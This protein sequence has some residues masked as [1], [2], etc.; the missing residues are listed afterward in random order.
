[1]MKAPSLLLLLFFCWPRIASPQCI[2]APA[3]PACTGTEP[4]LT[5]DETL[6]D[7]TTKWYYGPAVTMNSLTLNGGTL[8][9]CGDLTIDKF[10][11]DS[12]TVYVRPG[13]RFV[14]GSGIGSG[15]M[16]KGNSSFY[17]YGTFEIQ[18]NLS[19]ENGYA[20]AAKPNRV[21][22]ASLTSVFRMANQYLV[23]NNAFSWFVN[24]GSAECWGIITD[25]QA[26]PRSVCL[27]NHSSTQMA[28]LI[29]KVANT[30]VVPTGVACVRVFQ[31]SQFFGRLTGNS[32][33]LACL[34]ASHHSDTGCIPF[35]CQ[36]NNWGSAQV[37]T[38]CTD[39]ST[40]ISLGLQFTSFTAAAGTGMNKLSWQI[41]TAV[42]GGFFRIRRSTDGVHFYTIDS[43]AA[44]ENST[45]N[46]TS[47]DK[48][49]SPGT[50]YYMINYTNPNGSPSA[51]NVVKVI[52]NKQPGFTIFPVPFNDK[53]TISYPPGVT[54]E[55]IILTDMT[56]RN[57]GF[58]H[59]IRERS[60]LIEV[61]V[62]EK[63][64]AGIY[65]VH[66]LTNK[67]YMAQTILKK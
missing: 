22:N 3:A 15:L 66:L 29:N 49:P 58:R 31:L 61:T 57:I 52:S 38:N 64:E 60:Q 51:T 55:K 1:M 44:N 43:V 28:I 14:I 53:F 21:I 48:Y 12:G 11:I 32:G 4:L 37:F 41:N 8:V 26:S 30:Y 63:M 35:G 62:V 23:I 25:Q 5:N 67:K 2:V 34:G 6:P 42:P 59:S 50:N 33:L 10:Y 56:G 18:R 19:L 47:L 24:N 7:G 17:N 39:C 65:I 36:P 45:N 27:G 13:A 46:F 9:V 16:L 40:L 20:T 54:P